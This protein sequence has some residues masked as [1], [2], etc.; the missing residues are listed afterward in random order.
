MLESHFT[1]RNY[2]LLLSLALFLFAFL[3]Y[4][5]TVP[6]GYAL[7]DA[8]YYTNNRFVQQGFKGIPGIL[9]KSTYFGF[10]GKN[11]QIYRP[12]PVAV[13]AVEQA[14][15]GNNPHAGHLF[16][17]IAYAL[18]CVLLFLFLRRLLNGFSLMIPLCITLLFTAHPIHTEAVAN[19]KGL[20]EILAF[21][22]LVLTL[23]S[24]V[25][26]ADRPNPLRLAAG[27]AAYFLCLLSKEHGLTLVFIMPFML[28]VFRP[29]SMK[30]V[31]LS[32]LPFCGVAL[33]YVALRNSVLDDFTFSQP[34]DLINNTLM[35]AD[36]PADRLATAFLILGRYLR[37]LFVPWPLCWDYSYNQIPITTWADPKAAV[38]FALYA[39]LFIYGVI[40]SLKKSPVAFGALFFL[41]SFAL[42][43]NLFVKIGVSLGER[44]LFTPSLGFCAAVVLSAARFTRPLRHRKPALTALMAALLLTY[45]C[46][47]VDRN[48]DWRSERTLFTADSRKNP[49][50]FRARFWL[51]NTFLDA[52]CIAKDPALRSA[53]LGRA[54]DEYRH[55]IAIYP[56]F[57][58]AWLNLGLAYRYLN[59]KERELDSYQKALLLDPDDVEALSNIGAVYCEKGDYGRAVDYV[60]KALAK[61]DDHVPSCVNMGYASA[62]LGR[63]SEALHWY[64]KALRTD[65][66]NRAA[67]ANLAGL[68]K[69]MRDTVRN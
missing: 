5:N 67:R 37:L 45:A 54:K 17:A 43:T 52:G 36:N 23:H 51:G 60:R 11:E 8:M 25:R 9:T 65:P 16:N 3:L 42:S 59:D 6:N 7:D 68:E 29:L 1:P 48:A 22:F 49:D 41:A 62:K 19:I 39:G 30:K 28:Y 14:A 10:N 32:A 44:L 34:L 2:P 24:I 38:S 46:I 57:S 69:M 58:Q 18:C 50:S 27:M 40:G 12:L 13:F 26:Y 66:E 20:D 33:L 64:G 31:L 4:Q 47:T 61:K 15:F 55:S 35:A 21:M 53:L 63:C 56:R